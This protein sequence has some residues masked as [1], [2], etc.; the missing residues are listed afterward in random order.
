LGQN[1]DTRRE[2]TRRRAVSV[3][4]HSDSND[5]EDVLDREIQHVSKLAQQKLPDMVGA[6]GVGT[7][8]KGSK[9]ISYSIP[10]RKRKHSQLSW[11]ER[12]NELGKKPNEKEMERSVSD[13][14]SS[15]DS[16]YSDWSGIP[17]DGSAPY[18]AD[19]LREDQSGASA[20]QV[21]LSEDADEIGTSGSLSDASEEENIRRRANEFKNW[22]REQSGLGDS[23]S[24]ISS[25][26][27]LAP[28]ERQAIVA[29]LKKDTEL[30]VSASTDFQAH[31]VN[32][33]P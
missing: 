8:L 12:L 33:S 20:E 19:N 6:A 24:N 23:V 28:Q 17:E 3:E 13:A 9:P 29:S 31:A 2:V 21:K 16:E 22:A 30:F 26:P 15:D 25:L 10:V 14:M 4:V 5:E 18:I 27:Q 7:A 1:K 11:R 32:N